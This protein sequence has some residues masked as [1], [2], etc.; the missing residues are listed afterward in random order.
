M[1]LQKTQFPAFWELCLSGT[2]QPTVPPILDGHGKPKDHSQHIDAH[3]DHKEGA[4]DSLSYPRKKPPERQPDRED[5]TARQDAL[6]DGD[7]VHRFLPFLAG[8]RAFRL[9]F[10]IGGV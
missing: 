3:F 7:G 10:G 1:G 4:A 2:L 6:Q 8:L 5:G 9:L